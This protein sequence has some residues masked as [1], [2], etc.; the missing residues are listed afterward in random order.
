MAVY[1]GRVASADFPVHMALMASVARVEA[2]RGTTLLLL[3]PTNDV[4]KRRMGA[5]EVSHLH[6]YSRS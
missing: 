6:F 3:G 5:T 4:L 1:S 2:D